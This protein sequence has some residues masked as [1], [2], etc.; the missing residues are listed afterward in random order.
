MLGILGE[1]LK[2][3]YVSRLKNQRNQMRPMTSKPIMCSKHTPA[4]RIDEK[5]EIPLVVGGQTD[6]EVLVNHR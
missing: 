3:T 6:E 4:A 5:P 2:Q 1:Q